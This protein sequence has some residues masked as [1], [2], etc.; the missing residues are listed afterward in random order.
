MIKGASAPKTGNISVPSID[1][2]NVNTSMGIQLKPIS[3]T[4]NRGYALSERKIVPDITLQSITTSDY[5]QGV[6]NDIVINEFPYAPS[7]SVN[8]SSIIYSKSNQELAL[9]S[10]WTWNRTSQYTVLQPIGLYG[11][12]TGAG[13]TIRINSN[14][15]FYMLSNYAGATLDDLWFRFG[16][17]VV[18]GFSQTLRTIT[19][20]RNMTIGS[21]HAY[22]YKV[23]IRSGTYYTDDSSR[24]IIYFSSAFNQDSPNSIA[25]TKCSFMNFDSPSSQNVFGV[26][27]T[28]SFGDGIP[29]DLVTL[30]EI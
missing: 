11:G 10:T 7:P 28:D 27:M 14:L 29:N 25:G 13:C 23:N 5:I 17:I 12:H 18:Y 30:H 2:S 15:E 21:I 4:A 3:I 20:V 24:S 1:L 19:S 8:P 16:P 6:S 9:D 22:V 26:S